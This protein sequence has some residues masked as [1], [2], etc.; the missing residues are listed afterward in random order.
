MYNK[1]KKFIQQILNNLPVTMELHLLRFQVNEKERSLSR[2]KEQFWNVG[3]FRDERMD[4]YNV[5]CEYLERKLKEMIQERDALENKMSEKERE[6]EICD[7]RVA[8]V[9]RFLK[10]HVVAKCIESN[11]IFN[12][13][14]GCK[15]SSGIPDPEIFEDSASG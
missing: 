3:E 1:T 4:A 8:H 10:E 7:K 11:L 2:W 9:E 6:I 5:Q 12:G 13:T 15:N 14:F